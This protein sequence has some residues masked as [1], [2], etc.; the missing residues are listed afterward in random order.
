MLE[1]KNNTF[2]VEGAS[3]KVHIQIKIS[4]MKEVSFSYHECLFFPAYWF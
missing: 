3:Y 1:A 2:F 4:K